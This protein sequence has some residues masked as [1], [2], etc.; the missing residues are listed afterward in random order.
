MQAPTMLKIPKKYLLALAV[1]LTGGL[2]LRLTVLGPTKIQTVRVTQRDL[3]AQVYGNGTV[4]AKVVVNIASKITGRLA[5]VSVDQGDMVKQGQVLAK[6]DLSE[7]QAQNRQAKASLA[8]AKKNAARFKALASKELVSLQE[9]EQ[10]ET[11][12]LLAKEAVVASRSR[13]DDATIVAP[14]DGIIIRREL[15]PGATVTAGLPILLLANPETVWV[16]ANVDESQLKGLTPGQSATITLRSAPGE[17][18]PGQV[19]RLAWESDRVTEEL[20]VDVAF[21]P[22]VANFRLGEQAEVLITTGARKDAPSIPN[23][24]LANK[25][26]QRGVWVVENNRLLFRAVSTGI[27]D[28]HGMIEITAGLTG[29]EAIALAPPEKMSLLTEGQKVRV[30]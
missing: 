17:K 26:K 27:E 18:F 30:R 8:L 16:K 3:I 7:L 22:P 6:L 14:E 11:A 9:A 13:L 28:S 19:A 20:E 23:T 2:L 24:V 15:E 25:G 4:E 12:F 29:N 5:E 1:I 10:Y 21:T